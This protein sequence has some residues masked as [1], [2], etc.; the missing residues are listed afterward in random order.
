MRK[1]FTAWVL[2]KLRLKRVTIMFHVV[3]EEE[4]VIKHY[5]KTI[6]RKE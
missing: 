2:K 6:K 3:G 1:R 5:S 4:R